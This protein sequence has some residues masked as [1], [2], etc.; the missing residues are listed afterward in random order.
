[1][2]HTTEHEFCVETTKML[3]G[4]FVGTGREVTCHA[5]APW[6]YFSNEQVDMLLLD[7]KRKEYLCIEYKL[8]DLKSL[9][10]QTQIR[11]NAVGFINTKLREPAYWVFGYTGLDIQIEHIAKYLA[12]RRT[13]H[14]KSIYSGFGMVYYWAYKDEPN[15]FDGGIP[16]G[17]REGFASMYMRAIRNLHK[18]YGKLDFMLTHAALKSGYSAATSKKY[19]RKV[20]P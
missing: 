14:W 15:N 5:E 9:K 11:G 1:M 2:T 6:S 20:T 4:L 13:I 16:G 8:S 7:T 19:Y 3:L 18:H 10:H 12:G 17:G